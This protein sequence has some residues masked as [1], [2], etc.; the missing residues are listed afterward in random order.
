MAIHITLSGTPDSVNSG[1]TRYGYKPNTGTYLDEYFQ[2]WSGEEGNPFASPWPI[3]P[4]RPGVARD[5]TTGPKKLT[6]RA[7]FESTPPAKRTNW[8]Q[9]RVHYDGGP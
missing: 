9:T 7:L 1:N 6:R 5:S 2:L 3:E 4:R 8:K